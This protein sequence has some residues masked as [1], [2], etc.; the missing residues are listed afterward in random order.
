M[1][2]RTSL[3]T[4]KTKQP[5]INYQHLTPSFL[6]VQAAIPTTAITTKCFRKC[7]S[8]TNSNPNP[9]PNTN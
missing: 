5:L 4:H 2:L 7:A 9:N 3:E 1:Q 6:R 8:N